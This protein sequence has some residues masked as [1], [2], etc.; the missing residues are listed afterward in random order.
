[1]ALFDGLTERAGRLAGDVQVSLKRARL[2]GDR[3]ILQRAHRGTLE[4]LG[5]RV[6]ECVQS[7]QIPDDLFA[8]EYA[9]VESK[10]MEIAA[11]A[12]ETKSVRARDETGPHDEPD[13]E[14]DAAAAFPMLDD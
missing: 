2:E 7:G 13:A 10:S 4:A 1:M 14:T 9:A 12:E 3:R 5:A 6:Y 11:N 8:S